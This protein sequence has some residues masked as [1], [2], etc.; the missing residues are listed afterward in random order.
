[1]KIN[2]IFNAKLATGSWNYMEVRGL[3]CASAKN[4]LVWLP[5][6]SKCELVICFPLHEWKPENPL[7]C[8]TLMFGDSNHWF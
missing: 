4:F 5:Q 2:S 6:I 7:S 8:Q 1:M 3:N